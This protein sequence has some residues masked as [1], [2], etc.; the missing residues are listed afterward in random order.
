M[1]NME[2]Y[3]KGDKK[4]MMSR[5]NQVHTITLYCPLSDI[6]VNYLKETFNMMLA[7]YKRGENEWKEVPAIDALNAFLFASTFQEGLD[8]DVNKDVIGVMVGS[9]KMFPKL[10]YINFI[11]TND[12]EIDDAYENL[13]KRK[14]VTKR[15]IYKLEAIEMNLSDMFSQVII[16][17]VNKIF[18]IN[19]L[20]PNSY[21]NRK[22]FMKFHFD[23]YV[24]FMNMFIGNNKDNLM[25]LDKNI[26]DYFMSFPQ[27]VIEQKPDVRMITNYSE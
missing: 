15:Y 11:F 17:M 2:F 14:K 7:Y 12:K 8:V 20:I 10:K 3:T 26:C 16:D 23:D 19:E 25:Q 22:F 24:S 5:I 18:M 6:C 13:I 9:L 27:M 1:S 21:L 4:D